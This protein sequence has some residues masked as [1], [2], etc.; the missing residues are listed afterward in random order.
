MTAAAG[1]SI[2]SERAAIE[3]PKVLVVED[4]DSMREAV[5]R[6]LAAA[7]FEPTTYAS[8]E[9]LLAAGAGEG[10]VCV[11]SDLRL[12]VMSGLDMLAELRAR[13][14]TVPLVLI[15]GHD[16]PGLREDAMRRG[17]AAYLAKPFPGTTLLKAV[18][19]AIARRNA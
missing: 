11:V 9:A 19:A 13:G 8:A 15:T 4:D 10:A 17:A 5:T 7:G 6:L 12:P 1:A 3:G 18:Q 16:A 14:A 2:S